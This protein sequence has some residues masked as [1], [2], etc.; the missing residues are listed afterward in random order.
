MKQSYLTKLIQGESEGE[1]SVTENGTK[2]L[3]DVTSEKFR[4]YIGLPVIQIAEKLGLVT[5]STKPKS[6]N[7]LLVKRVLGNGTGSIV[8]FE[9]A[10]IQI[11]TIRLMAN[12]MPKEAMS[13]S[14]FSFAELTEQTWVDSTFH[15]QT[16][17]KFLF[18]VF[19]IDN[20]GTER[21]ET[22][23][24][25]NMPYEDRCQARIVWEATASKVRSS[26][27]HFPKSS[28][29]SVAHVRPH[30]RNAADT[31][32]LPDGSRFTKQSFWLNRQ[33]IASVIRNSKS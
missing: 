21:L 23:Q 16:E 22:V 29:N 4:P 2:T 10:G 6:F 18:I 24:Y 15:R 28:E 19:R 1:V 26:N 33:Y 11:K 25:W 13:F 9:K 31:D 8:E 20:L 27:T 5:T 17:T 3:E 30:G 32:V 14:S 7:F 12:G